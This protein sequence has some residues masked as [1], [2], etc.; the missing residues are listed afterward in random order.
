MFSILTHSFTVYYL[1][2]DVITEK[3]CVYIVNMLLVK[4]FIFSRF[5]LLQYLYKVQCD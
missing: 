5:K 3:L 1:P 4:I 2:D